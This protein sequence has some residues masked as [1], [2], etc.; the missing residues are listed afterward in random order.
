MARGIVEQGGM[1]G[2]RSEEDV[3]AAIADVRAD[4]KI[5]CQTGFDMRWIWGQKQAE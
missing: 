4:V 5:G 1:E 2:L 3:E